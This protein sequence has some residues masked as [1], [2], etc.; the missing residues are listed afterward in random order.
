MREPLVTVFIP[1][2]NRLDL[3]RRAVNSVV[4]QSY[5]NI[6]LIIIDDCSSDG[7]PDYLEEISKEHEWILH[8]RNDTNLGACRSR[9]RGISAAAGEFITGLDDDDYFR[10]TRISDFVEY[11]PVKRK[12]TVALISSREVVRPDNSVLEIPGEASIS[13]DD[14]YLRNLVGSQAFLETKV[15]RQLG[16]F[17]PEL[18]A[19]QDYEFFIRLL[20]LGPVENT[21]R[22]TYVVDT[23]H[24][25]ARITTGDYDKV[26]RS[27]DYIIDKHDITGRNALRIRS[28][29][30]VY[31]F[32]ITTAV[33]FF[34]EF[35]LCLDTDGL[36][37]V[38][39]R[40]YRAKIV[41]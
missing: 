24:R 11:W 33:R 9:N 38:I 25:Y 4:S 6:E 16:G 41:K 32:R 5:G 10:P 22:N 2:C 17:D 8:L 19:W 13:I 31:R 28:Q 26:V 30:L 14:I 21:F 12:E 36:K 1:T 29:L 34:L 37:A 23:S 3:L 15:A 7:T 35:L 40:F 27:C 18:P 39:M 20:Q